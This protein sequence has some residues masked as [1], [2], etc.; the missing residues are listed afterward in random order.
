MP[1]H[2]PL[3]DDEQCEWLVTYPAR[4]GQ[5]PRPTNL[6][7]TRTQAEAKFGPGWCEPILATRSTIPGSLKGFG[8]YPEGG[9]YLSAV[10]TEK[11]PG[12]K[13]RG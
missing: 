13:A 5:P 4:P 12:P 9:G 10:E 1:D 8:L 7:Y 3:R 6:P 11:P 2:A